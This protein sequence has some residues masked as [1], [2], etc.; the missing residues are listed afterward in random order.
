MNWTLSVSEQLE[1]EF[2]NF[3]YEI[4]LDSLFYVDDCMFGDGCI[5]GI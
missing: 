3:V 5:Y 1:L 4:L 2:K